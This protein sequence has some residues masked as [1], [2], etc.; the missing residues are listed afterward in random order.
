MGKVSDNPE[1]VSFLCML[2]H[3]KAIDDDF[4]IPRKGTAKKKR[5]GN[6]NFF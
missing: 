1:R 5:V 6:I 2:S 3:E 4:S